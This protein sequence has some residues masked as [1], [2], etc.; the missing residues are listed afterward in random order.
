MQSEIEIFL[1]EVDSVHLDAMV[2][3]PTVSPGAGNKPFLSGGFSETHQAWWVHQDKVS[4]NTGL[5]G[6]EM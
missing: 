4:D 2:F 5:R 1:Y 3:L 6:S